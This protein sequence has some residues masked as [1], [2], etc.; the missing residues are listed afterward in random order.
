MRAAS[1]IITISNHGTISANAITGSHMESSVRM[2]MQNSYNE[3]P[4]VYC[5]NVM[6]STTTY[7]RFM[8]SLRLPGGDCRSQI[9]VQIRYS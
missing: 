1:L 6:W 2:T 4:D 5:T 7:Y 8:R 3:N 9:L